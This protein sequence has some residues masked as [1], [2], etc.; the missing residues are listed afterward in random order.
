MTEVAQNEE[1]CRVL[2]PTITFFQEAGFRWANL[3]RHKIFM[4]VFK[5]R[6]DPMEPATSQKYWNFMPINARPG[7]REATGYGCFSTMIF[8]DMPLKRLF[9]K[10]S[11]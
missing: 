5:V 7:Q 2:Y 4:S 6:M 11:T 3:L 8:V 1:K 9:L 10:A